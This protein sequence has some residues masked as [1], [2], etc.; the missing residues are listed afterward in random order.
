MLCM[1]WN[2]WFEFKDNLRSRIAIGFA[3]ITQSQSP[4]RERLGTEVDCWCPPSY[5]ISLYWCPA[6]RLEGEER[7]REREERE[8]RKRRGRRGSYRHIGG[9]PHNT[10]THSCKHTHTH[11]HTHTQTHTQSPIHVHV[12]STTHHSLIIDTVRD[13]RIHVCLCLCVWERERVCGS[14]LFAVHSYQLI[15]TINITGSI[16]LVFLNYLL[17]VNLN[18]LRHLKF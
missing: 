13:W 3:L 12:H 9:Q 14:Q 4:D 16:R 17:N 6:V 11:T 2:N 15:D 1:K 7:E 10:H 8:E 5:A 18:I